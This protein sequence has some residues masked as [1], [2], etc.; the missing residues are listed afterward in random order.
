MKDLPTLF[1]LVLGIALVTNAYGEITLDSNEYKKLD[2]FEAYSLKKAEKAFAAK[3]WRK[4]FAEYD[5][6]MLEYPRSTA[7]SYAVFRKARCLHNDGKRF[8]AVEYYNEVLDYFPNHVKYAGAAL[9]FIGQCHL[10]NGDIPRALKAWAEMA[11]DVDYRKHFMAATA[12]NR[13]ADNLVKQKK[14]SHAIKY[15][16][17]V[18]IDFRK[19]NA[20]A[21]NY[22][23]NKV[24]PYYA[25]VALDEEELRKFYLQVGAFGGSPTEIPRDV[26]RYQPY[27]DYVRKMIGQYGKFG[28]DQKDLKDRYYRYW[29]SLMA[30]LFG[31]WDDFQIDRIN[32]TLA[33]EGSRSKWTDRMDEQFKK[34]QKAEDWDRVLRWM[35]IFKGNEEKKEEYYKM[36][37]FQKMNWQTIWR[38]VGILWDEF[39]DPEMAK[40]TFRKITLED[41]ADDDKSTIAGYMAGKKEEQLVVY[42]YQIFDDRDR[43]KF[44]LMN[45]YKG[46]GKTDEALVLAQELTGVPTYALD[47][48]LAMASIFEGRKEWQKAIGCYQSADNPPSN[49]YAIANCYKQL[50][51]Y[52]QAIQQLREIE[53]FFKDQ[54]PKAALMIATYFNAAKQRSQYVAALR[55]VL[56]KYPKSGE[57]SRAHRLLERMGERIGGGQN[58]D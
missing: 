19:D 8:K 24:V 2:T 4:A 45:Y 30:G 11:D 51:K 10:D 37:L 40:N 26:K 50:N 5:S 46:V 14:V 33:Y 17:Q 32:Y 57:S 54:S 7:T 9:F 42:I 1:H 21:A 25:R 28:E 22:A 49:L 55:N 18:A 20:G 16:R 6:F 43:G 52:P 38:L 34:Y 3:E 39:K 13:L 12:I 31:S 41:L 56:K 44:E 36:L 27:W 23:I 53:A 58:A 47:A 35:G 15:Y 29:T 48:W